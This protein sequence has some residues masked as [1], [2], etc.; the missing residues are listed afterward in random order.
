MRRIL[1]TAIALAVPTLPRELPAQGRPGAVELGFD[2]QFEFSNPE[3]LDVGDGQPDIE[4][5]D[6]VNL[7]IPLQRF[8]VGYHASDKISLEPSIG[9]DY[10]K[11]EDPDDDS[12]AG[13][14]SV[15][16]VQLGMAVLIHFLADPD[17][18]VAYAIGR[19]TYNLRDVNIGDDD[20]DGGDEDEARSQFGAALGVG[21]KLP[22]AE[23]LDVRLEGTYERRFEHEDDGLPSSNNYQVRV[24]FSWYTGTP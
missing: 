18:P 15:T 6:R 8:R 11:V 5:G 7:G 13:D 22:A 23:K 20:D 9:L 17:S 10:D 2:A 21:V 19:G 4:F 16:E 14:R 24:G 1:W 3:D 12:D